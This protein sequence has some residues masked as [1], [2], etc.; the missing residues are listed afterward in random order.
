MSFSLGEYPRPSEETLAVPTKLDYR[1][2]F[3]PVP[4]Q[5]LFPGVR[6]CM[7]PKASPPTLLSPGKPPLTCKA[8]ETAVAAAKSMNDPEV[9]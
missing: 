2:R 1:R 6:Q 7:P 9:Q 4:C 5:E 3:I 8:A